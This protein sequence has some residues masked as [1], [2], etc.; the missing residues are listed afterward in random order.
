MPTLPTPVE[1]SITLEPVTL[2]FFPNPNHRSLCNN[3]DWVSYDYAQKDEAEQAGYLHAERCCE[4]LNLEL[5]QQ[6]PVEPVEAQDLAHGAL[7]LLRDL[8]TMAV[9]NVDLFDDDVVITYSIDG[10]ESQVLNVP[11]GHSVKVLV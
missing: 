3:C 10:Q 1:P 4:R 7:I 9:E 5:A 11:V 2:R 6:V 8:R